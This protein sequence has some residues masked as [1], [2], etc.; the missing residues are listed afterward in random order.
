MDEQ[1]GPLLLSNLKIKSSATMMKTEIA[2]VLWLVCRVLVWQQDEYKFATNP[3]KA[4]SNPVQTRA[5]SPKNLHCYRSLQ[6]YPLPI[7]SQAIR[8]T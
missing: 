8:S 1:E 4:E 5:L 2:P 3:L 7:E 6:F